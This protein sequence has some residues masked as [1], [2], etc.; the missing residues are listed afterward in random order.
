MKG[1]TNGPVIIPGD[2]DTSSLVVL[3]AGNHPGKFSQSELD[4]IKAWITAG[5]PES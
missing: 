5:A 4:R 2:A 3:Q 1:T